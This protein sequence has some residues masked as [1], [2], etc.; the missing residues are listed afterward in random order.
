ME[1]MNKHAQALSALGAAKGG[2]ARAAALT[3]E[4]R[5]DIARMAAEKRWS[6]ERDQ[7]VALAMPRETHPGILRIG[8]RQIPCSVL[9]NGLRVLS[10]GGVSRALGSRKVGRNQPPGEQTEVL[11][12]L[13]PFLAAKNLQP[14][15]PGDLL[16]LLIS[17]VRYKPWRG[18]R[19]G[20]G[21]EATLL[22]RICGV[23]LDAHKAGALR[24]NQLR[25]V[26]I[27]ELLLRGFAHVGI[28]ALV[29]EA[30]GYQA[31]RAK[32]ELMRILEAYI[33]K[34]LLPW[35]QRFPDDFFKEIYRLHGWQF[36][37]GHTRGPRIV[38]KLIRQLVYDQLPR[39]VIQ[40]LEVRNP[41]LPSGWRRHK[42]HQ[43]LT[44]DIGHPHLNN[45]VASVMTL[46]RASTSKH[47]FMKLFAR[48]FPKPGQGEQLEL[49]E[50]EEEVS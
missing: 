24:S 14:F 17:P 15:I 38:G 42:H 4:E 8:D 3:A 49:P 2:K 46:M 29:D 27:A 25:L 13:P 16:A 9:D 11:P 36:R 47:E 40:E 5:S 21:Y 33:S 44:E 30:T 43:F 12:Q 39:G 28:I 32:D 31:E 18:G 35:T 50:S 22:P 6:G 23:I 20:Y 1:Q 45:Q 48:A 7:S 41:Q 37:E 19:V 26:E 34:A 10:A